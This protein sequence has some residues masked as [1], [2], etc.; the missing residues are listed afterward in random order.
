MNL[1]QKKPPTWLVHI[2]GHPWVLGQATGTLDHKTHHGSDLGEATTFPHIVF[3]APHFG[4]QRGGGENLPSSQIRETGM[5]FLTIPLHFGDGRLRS[6]AKRPPIGVE[7]LALLGGERIMDQTFADDTALY[8]QGTRGNMERAQK[9]LDI[10][11]KASEAKIN[12]NKSCAIWASKRNRNGS[13]AE[14]W[15]S[16]GSL[17][18]KE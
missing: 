1:H 13:G 2:P 12:W 4:A 5:P 18:E 7:G 9:V 16:S 17:K 11:C 3:S 10:F 6:H 8:L 15:D 14:R